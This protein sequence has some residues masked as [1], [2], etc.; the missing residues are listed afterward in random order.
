MRSSSQ[1]G[2]TVWV[3][4]LGALLHCLLLVFDHVSAYAPFLRGDRSGLRWEAFQDFASAQRGEVLLTLAESEVVPGEFIFHYAPYLLAGIPGMIVFQIALF[5]LSLYLVCRIA[6]LVGLSPKGTFWVGLIY[7][8]LPHNIA[9]PHQFVTEAISTPLCVL[10]LY[11]LL[12]A[13]R[14]RNLA[15][16]VACGAALGLAILA[17]PSLGLVVP[18]VAFGAVA[19][20]RHL[21]EGFLRIAGAIAVAAIAPM[22][23]WVTTFSLVTGSVG[24]TNGVANLGWNLRSK[25]F[26][27]HQSTGTAMPPELEGFS[28]YGELYSDPSGI[29]LTRFAELAAADSGPFV[30]AAAT[31]AAIVL[32][33]GNVTKVMV[34]YLGV[35]D[36]TEVKAW[37]DHLAS[38]GVAG[39][40]RWAFAE[41]ELVTL[42]GVEVLA[43]AL[44][45][46]ASAAVLLIGFHSVAFPSRT[47]TSLSPAAYL[48]VLATLALLL[49]SLASGLMVDRAQGRMRHPA[50][51]GM[52][53]TLAI[54]YV[55]LWGNVRFFKSKP[56]K[57]SKA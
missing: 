2:A 18:V 25:V 14:G 55:Y 48:L 11:F 16:A 37:R 3:V 10:F 53:L 33:R 7:L 52:I 39:L 36:A 4:G 15:A 6:E 17:R 49:T 47:M 20:H 34:D 54:A 1:Q 29:S 27:V 24:Y 40:L 26:L 57:R 56:P 12:I 43:S 41:W 45:A 38:G 51:A 9:F 19:L 28:T 5:L 23:A 50:E 35:G 8:L 32:A 21:P 42:V 13:G 46:L 22:A 30:S 44:T 31:D